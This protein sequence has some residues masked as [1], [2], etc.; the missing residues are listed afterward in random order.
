M[1]EPSETGQ[2]TLLREVNYLAD[3]D[4]DHIIEHWPYLL[5]EQKMELVALLDEML[6]DRGSC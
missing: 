3:E 6:A 5:P 1:T 4:L 2:E